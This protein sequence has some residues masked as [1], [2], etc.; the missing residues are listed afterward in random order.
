VG[1]N[2][3]TS[4]LAHFS[5]SPGTHDPTCRAVLVNLAAN[6]LTSLHDTVMVYS[7]KQKALSGRL[8]PAGDC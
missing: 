2:N 6:W 1:I 5:A 7:Y 8:T 4:A 3:F